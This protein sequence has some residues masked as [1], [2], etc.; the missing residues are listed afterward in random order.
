MPGTNR[1]AEAVPVADK[2]PP[3][4]M[5]V[6]RQ[7]ERI[8]AE[9]IPDNWSLRAGRSAALGRYRVDLRAEIAS[10][11]GE[12]A[13]LAV[14]IK[15]TLEPRDVFQ[16]VERI[17]MITAGPQ[18]RAPWPLWRPP[19]SSPRLR[20]LLRVRGVGYVDTT[21]NVRI[22]VSVPGLF[23]STDGADRDPWPKDHK[24]RSVR[25]RGAARA[26]RAI[27]D[28]RAPYGVRELAQS[29][30]ALAPTL[31]RVLD[32]LEREAIVTRVRGAAS[33]VD[34]QAAIR[35]WAEDYDQTDCNAPTTVLEPRGLPGLENRLRA[36]KSRT[37][38]PALSQLSDSTP[39]QPPRWRLSTSPTRAKPSTT[40]S[41]GRRRP[42]PTSCF[43]S[44]WI[45][46]SSTGRSNAT[47]F[48]VSLPA[49]SPLTC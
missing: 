1:S 17:S 32:L 14:E 12:N 22:E 24:L 26:M 4:G 34:W 11:T 7:I 3:S 6:R 41:P 39:S 5:Q 18:C 30:G 9:R 40:W 36:M 10:P 25:G 48:A 15:R 37:P 46:S 42:V 35:Q 29:T 2:Q 27:V 44:L 33:T 16:A 31:S 19:T 47:V 49:S 8:L 23:V 21:G 45:L 43:S 20:I 28:T 13:V 38:R